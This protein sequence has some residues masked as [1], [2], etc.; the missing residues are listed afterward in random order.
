LGFV[1]CFLIGD[2]IGAKTL[3]LMGLIVNL[4]GVFKVVMSGSLMGA[5]YGM[6]FCLFGLTI[7]YGVSF[8]FVTETVGEE[9]RQSYKVIL[10]SIYSLGGVLN[11][12]WFYLLPNFEMIMI[13]C[14]QLPTIL[15]ILCFLF[16]FKDTPITLLTRKSAE[17][18]QRDLRIIARLNKRAGFSLTVE[19][20]RDMQRRYKEEFLA[21]QP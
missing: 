16:F 6:F 15:C 9:K 5:G 4:I 1:C 7:T 13:L 14:Y 20:V 18:A 12:L 2:L 17:E 3:M 8:T 21:N 19:E 10:S 11:V